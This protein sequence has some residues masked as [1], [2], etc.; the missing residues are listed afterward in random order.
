VPNSNP[1][2]KPKKNQKKDRSHTKQGVTNRGEK[3]RFLGQAKIC[4]RT[5]LTRGHG[6]GTQVYPRGR[7]RFLA[8]H[9]RIN[10]QKTDKGAPVCGEFSELTHRKGMQVPNAAK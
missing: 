8:K 4:E 9:Y 5:T 2:Q 6:T 10:P 3:F 1:S 7:H